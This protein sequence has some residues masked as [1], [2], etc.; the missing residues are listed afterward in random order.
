VLL[1]GLLGGAAFAL[2]GAIALGASG[3]SGGAA[4]AVVG[5]DHIGACI[6]ALLCGVLFVPVYG[7]VVAALLLA[8][9]KLSSALLLFLARRRAHAV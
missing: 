3:R 4:A 1:T 6:G 2:A 7:I 9:V 8:A 5:A